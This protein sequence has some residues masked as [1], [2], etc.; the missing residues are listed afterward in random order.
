M[1]FFADKSDLVAEIIA[2]YPAG[3]ERS[4]V[5]P[6]LRE[7]QTAEGYVSDARVAEIAAI[8]GQT[9]TEVKSVMIAAISA[10]RAS[11]T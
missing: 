11:E 7:V 3:R 1:S 10:T 8:I 4:A 5:M 2:K 6:L 9:A